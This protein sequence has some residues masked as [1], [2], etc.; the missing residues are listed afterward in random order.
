MGQE[1]DDHAGS[2]PRRARRPRA[3]DPGGSDA[4]VVRRVRAPETRD[5]PTRLRGHAGARPAPLRPAPGRR[6]RHPISVLRV[7]RRRVPGRE[8]AAGGA[9][10]AVARP[11]RRPLRGGRRLSDDLRVH[12]RVPRPPAGLHPAVPARDGRPSRGE[13]PVHAGGPRPRE[14]ARCSHGRVE[15]DPPADQA[16]GTATDRASRTERERRGRRRRR[17]GSAA[18][19]R[20]GRVARGDRGALPDQ[21]PVGA[22][23]GGLRACRHPLSGA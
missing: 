8:P 13:L 11:P 6:R 9:P 4:P 1:P 7:H 2:V 21:R 23:R 3:A 19:S 17:R 14:S 22:V 12:G 10:G 18:S 5:G 16:L 20:R 15:Q